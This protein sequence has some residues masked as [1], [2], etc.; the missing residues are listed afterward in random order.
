M[1]KKCIQIETQIIR[2][3]SSSRM[4]TK[5]NHS[6][7]SFVPFLLK[8]SLNVC[9]AS[10]KTF[11]I[12][13]IIRMIEQKLDWYFKKWVIMILYFIRIYFLMTQRLNLSINGIRLEQYKDYEPYCTKCIIKHVNMTKS[14]L[15]KSSSKWSCLTICISHT[16]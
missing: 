2:Y 16:Y 14:W 11:V 3:I 1:Y 5:Q 10:M 4:K 7:V 6:I 12:E 9:N 8:N 15:L 13:I